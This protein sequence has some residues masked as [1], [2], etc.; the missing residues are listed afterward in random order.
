MKIRI[1]HNISR[2]A[3]FGLNTVIGPTGERGAGERHPLV[4][5]FEYEITAIDTSRIE[6]PIDL[7][8]LPGDVLWY[9][10]TDPQSALIDADQVA[11]NHAFEEFNI[12]E[13]HLAQAY[14]ARR[15]R[16]L[17]VG[18]VV[19]IDGRIYSCESAG[20][21]SRAATELRVLPAA[22][23]DAA[24]RAAYGFGPDEELSVTVPLPD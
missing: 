2:D 17:S 15:L 18:D 21:S 1:Y 13:G 12:G 11:L 6:E 23:A 4:W 14:R 20:W 3:S 9:D 7:G 24:I 22:E 5:V 16:S 19:M 8:Q 10:G